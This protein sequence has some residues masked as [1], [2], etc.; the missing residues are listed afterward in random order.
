MLFRAARRPGVAW[1]GR[2]LAGAMLAGW[3]LF[4]FVEGLIDHQILGL[5][6]VRPGENQL[7]WD[8][9]FLATGPLFVLLGMRIAR[10]A[11]RSPRRRSLSAADV[12][13]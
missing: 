12:P 8:L 7:A 13:A 6:H 10:S 2:V 5:H 9:A 4:N 1:D 11:R 3:G